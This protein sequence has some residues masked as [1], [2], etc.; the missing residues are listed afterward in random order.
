MA[1]MVVAMDS[2]LP[3]CIDEWAWVGG[4]GLGAGWGGGVAGLV[5]AAAAAPSRPQIWRARISVVRAQEAE[6]R[7][8]SALAQER[9]G[10][11]RGVRT[12]QRLGEGI[13]RSVDRPLHD[14]QLAWAQ[15]LIT[16]PHT[17]PGGTR[18]AGGGGAGRQVRTVAPCL[19]AGFAVFR[20]V[21]RPRAV[22][23]R[24]LAAE[25]R[26]GLLE[27]LA[28][29]GAADPRIPQRVQLAGGCCRGG[30]LSPH[31]VGCLIFRARTGFLIQLI[32]YL[33]LYR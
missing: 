32:F 16:S 4:D 33:Y 29:D 15:R 12:L 28:V 3:P 31:P 5:L 30:L 17:L 25:A 23:E 13:R 21:V 2:A 8:L 9:G 27:A 19:V 1:I 20:H 10:R 11:A 14:V 6:R 7:Q 26:L 18:P 24:A 22:L